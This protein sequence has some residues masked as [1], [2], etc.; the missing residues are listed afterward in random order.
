CTH[1]SPLPRP[2]RRSA[3]A[4]SA[5]ASRIRGDARW[6]APAPGGGTARGCV[7]RLALSTCL[8]LYWTPSPGLRIIATAVRFSR[9]PDS[10]LFHDALQRMLMF[11]GKVHHLRH[12]GFRHF[13][14]KNATFADAVVMDVKHDPG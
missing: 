5:R 11:A 10:L 14:G 9:F 13:I 8:H 6:R 2:G 7:R 4:A 1:A 12:L 3:R